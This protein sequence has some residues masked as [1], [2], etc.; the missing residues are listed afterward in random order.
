MFVRAIMLIRRFFILIKVCD[1]KTSR[2]TVLLYIMMLHYWNFFILLNKLSPPYMKYLN[3]FLAFQ[4]TAVWAVLQQCFWSWSCLVLVHMCIMHNLSWRVL[5]RLG[6]PKSVAQTIPVWPLSTR[7]R[8][9]AERPIRDVLIGFTLVKASISTTK[10]AYLTGLTYSL[11]SHTSL[12]LTG[13]GARRPIFWTHWMKSETCSEQQL[14]IKIFADNTKVWKVVKM[15]M[16]L[17]HYRK[18]D[19]N[20]LDQWTENG[21]SSLILRSAK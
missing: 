12:N 7:V 10:Q 17:G 1:V 4:S 8:N 6:G 3:L 11:S 9:T 15:W 5:L 13:R 16:I 20:T 18:E 2:H 21:C 14:F 19:L